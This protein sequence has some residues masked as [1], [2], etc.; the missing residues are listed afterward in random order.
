MLDAF[1]R[2]DLQASAC[3]RPRP[4]VTG[5]PRK[6][7]ADLYGLAR[8]RL[9]GAGVSGVYGGAGCTFSEPARFFSH[10][11]DRRTGRLAALIWLDA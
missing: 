10:R 4:V 7:Y 11:R 2:A 6:W 1:T 5:T 3:F 8:Q 9:A